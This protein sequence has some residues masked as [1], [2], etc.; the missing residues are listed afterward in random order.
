MQNQGETKEITQGLECRKNRRPFS[1]KEEEKTLQLLQ[2]AK[3]MEGSVCLA[4]YLCVYETPGT[5]IFAVW[6]IYC[7]KL[8]F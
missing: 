2:H 1:T 3:R 7:L 5:D 4:G 6:V 8:V